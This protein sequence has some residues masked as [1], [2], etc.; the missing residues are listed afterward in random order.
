MGRGAGGA[1]SRR[2]RGRPRRGRRARPD[3]ADARLGLPRRRAT[4]SCARRCC[5]TTSAPPRSARGSPSAS[6]RRGCSRS[7]AT[8]PSPASRRR[9]CAGCSTRSPRSPRAC[10]R[11]LLPKDYVRLRL[12]GE[13]ATD[14]SDASGTLLLDV[15][16]RDWSDELLEALEIPRAWLPDVREG[17]E[18]AGALRDDGGRRARAAGAGCRSPRAGA[19]T[20]PRRSASASSAEGLVSSSIGTSGVIFAHRDAFTPDP[21]GRVHAFCH[22]VPGRVPPHGGDAVGGRVAGLVARAGRR[23]RVLRRARRRGRGSPA[24][25]RGPGLPALPQRRAHAAPRPA[26]P[27]RVRRPR[28]APHARRT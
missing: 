18:Q 15:R 5:G 6:A 1:R 3:R 4:R 27:R 24:G 11:V 21:S 22:A 17:T 26:R 10:A 12:T 20:R 28:A 8:R 25:R 19:T 7:R 23:R 16:A 9:R 2:G 13:R 14:A